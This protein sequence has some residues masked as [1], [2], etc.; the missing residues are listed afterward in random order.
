MGFDKIEIRGGE[1]MKKMKTKLTDIYFP[2]FMKFDKCCI[3]DASDIQTM[4]R[5]TVEQEKLADFTQLV[6]KT[7]LHD[8]WTIHRH[9]SALIVWIGELPYDLEGYHHL[10]E[11]ALMLKHNG[12][13]QDFSTFDY[14]KRDGELSLN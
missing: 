11:I 4:K 10:Y 7:R 3:D 6:K 14:D 1:T 12:L 13:W 9:D 5:L 8:E 2:S